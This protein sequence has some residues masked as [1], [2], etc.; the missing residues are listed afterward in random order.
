[1]NKEPHLKKDTLCKVWDNTVPLK[2]RLRYADG[3]G[4]FFNDGYKSCCAKGSV[5]W[6]NFEVVGL[7][8]D[9]LTEVKLN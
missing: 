9:V 8:S 5:K 2:D 4:G 3:K 6:K 7:Y 1:M